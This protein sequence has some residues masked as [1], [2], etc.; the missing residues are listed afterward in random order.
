MDIKIYQVCARARA[1]KPKDKALIGYFKTIW[2]NYNPNE[3]S[4]IALIK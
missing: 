1:H 3:S 4:K 2:T